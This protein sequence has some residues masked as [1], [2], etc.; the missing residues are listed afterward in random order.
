M[1]WSE[2]LTNVQIYEDKDVIA[3]YTAIV[4]TI[5]YYNLVNGMTHT[6]KTSYTINDATF[7]L[8]APTNL[9]AGTTFAGCCTQQLQA[10]QSDKRST[11]STEIKCF[12]LS[13]MLQ[14]IQFSMY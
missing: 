7:N 1:A 13:L 11:G 6:N 14:H 8:T 5:N 10:E 4:Y 2:N 12:M 9:P 3:V